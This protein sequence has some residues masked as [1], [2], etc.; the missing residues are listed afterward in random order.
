MSAGLE[1][2]T[3]SR[4]PSVLDPLPLPATGR[5][6]GVCHLVLEV[7]LACLGVDP[8][9]SCFFVVH[10]GVTIAQSGLESSTYEFSGHPSFCPSQPP[11]FWDFPRHLLPYLICELEDC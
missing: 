4:L 11:R 5:V 9:S 3:C 7:L 10:A 6:E 2:N 1:L 8:C